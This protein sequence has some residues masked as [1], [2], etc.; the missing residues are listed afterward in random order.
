MSKFSF[1]NENMDVLKI[2]YEFGEWTQV[3]RN[4]Y[5]VGEVIEEPIGTE[6]GKEECSFILTGFFRGFKY[7]DIEAI[8]NKIKA[9]FNPTTGLSGETS[10]GCIVAFYDKADYIPTGE[11]DLK[12]IQINL[13]IKEWKKGT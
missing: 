4:D 6:D 10:T 3:V 13:K 12:K 5:F 9:H 2:P 7:S 8:K 1:I 11:T